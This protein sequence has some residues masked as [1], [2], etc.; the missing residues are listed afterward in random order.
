MLSG[1]DSKEEYRAFVIFDGECG[2]CNKTVGYLQSRDLARSFTFVPYQSADLPTISPGLTSS[3]ATQAVFVVE[4][5]GR[6]YRGARGMFAVLRRLSGIWGV[7]GKVWF[8]PPLSLIA[9]PFYWLFARNR[10]TISRWLGLAG[11][12]I[13]ESDQGRHARNP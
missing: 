3:M 2:V 4:P 7:V 9:E 6:R 5:H 13:P 1:Q 12:P 10:R 8:L 11:C